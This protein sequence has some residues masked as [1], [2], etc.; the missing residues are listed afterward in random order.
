VTDGLDQ[1]LADAGLNLLRA[2]ASLT[3]FDGAVP[4]PAPPNPPQPPPYVVV[5]CTI[6]WAFDP[7][8]T[9][10]TG[11]V[12]RATVRWTTHSVGANSQASRGV[13]Q[14]VR[15]QLLNVRPTVAGMNVGLIRDDQDSPPD[16][17]R[18]ETTGALVVD[19]IHVYSLIATT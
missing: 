18:D 2:D 9:A 5:Y 4:N 10:L 14:R 12:K 17:V 6:G 13:A 11:L 15:T 16:P 7:D 8:S 19:T 3:V 1:L